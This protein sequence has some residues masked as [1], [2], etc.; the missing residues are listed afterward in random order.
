MARFGRLPAS[1]RPQIGLAVLALCVAWLYL[2]VLQG[3]FVNWDDDGNFL[4][5]Y[6]FRGLAWDHLVWAWTTFHYGVYQPLAWMAFEAQY[7]AFGLQPMGYHAVSLGLVVICFITLVSLLKRLLRASGRTAVWGPSVVAAGLFCIHPLRVE[8]VAWVSA[9]PYLLCAIFYMLTL[10]L[11][12]RAKAVTSNRASTAAAVLAFACA[13]GFK[14]EAVSL[15]MALILIDVAVLRRRPRQSGPAV[16]AWSRMLLTG[17]L[18]FFILAA[19]TMAAAVVAKRQVGSIVDMQQFGGGA[20]LLLGA[21]RLMTPLAQTLWP[22]RLSIY[23]PLPAH[24]D[25][26]KMLPWLA[27]FISFGISLCLW[28]WRR[29]YPPVL[30]AWIMYITA[31]LPHVGYPQVGFM[32]TADRYSLLPSL[33]LAALLAAG[34][35]AVWR[36]WSLGITGLVVAVAGSLAYLSS[37]QIATWRSSV[38]LMQQAAAQISA[39]H[40]AGSEAASLIYYNLGVAL[41]ESNQRPAAIAALQAALEAQP[42]YMDAR[43]AL[44]LELAADGHLA[45][46]T[47]GWQALVQRSLATTQNGGSPKLG[48]ADLEN[49]FGLL[50]ADVNVPDAAIAAF[51][52]A[53]V[54]DPA[55]VDAYA[56]LGFLLLQHGQVDAA[57]VHLDRALALNPEHI[58]ALNSRAVALVAKNRLA[59]ALKACDAALAKDGDFIDALINRGIILARLGDDLGAIASFKKAQHRGGDRPEVSA[60]LGWALLRVGRFA[61]AQASFRTALALRPD[62]QT[63]KDGLAAHPQE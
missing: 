51:R 45:E 27:V 56:N 36:R 19:M 32:I 9:Q 37:I 63:A 7:C 54:Q 44:S 49:R 20:R 10:I 53:L 22:M 26:E 43:R 46:A 41:S 61:E 29:R 5:N 35:E 40:D 42:Y 24:F 34:L 21:E 14:A 15:P 25:P 8:V 18:P 58:F 59:E 55:H 31:M 13:L 38:S 23:H 17:K 2:P 6:Y 62:L 57:M 4:R 33:A 47:L 16:F 39:G 12:L 60:N 52:R 28:R 30:A 48:V 3:S 11:Y 50:L 1:W